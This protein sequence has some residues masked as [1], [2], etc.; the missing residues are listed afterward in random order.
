MRCGMPPPATSEMAETRCRPFAGAADSR[1]RS[2]TAM[3]T[4]TAAAVTMAARPQ[5]AHRR[6][7][8]HGI[9]QRPLE[10]HS[11]PLTKLFAKI[12]LLAEQARTPL[13]H[14]APLLARLVYGQ[15]FFLT[16]RG[17]WGRIDEIV[18]WFDSMH[19]PLAS[20]QAPFVATV[21]LV[22]GISLMLGLGTRVAAFLLS[23]TM[24][25]AL[26]TA[27]SQSFV[28]ALFLRGKDSLPAVTPVP[29]LLTLLLLI[30]FG[31]GK[32]SVDALLARRSNAR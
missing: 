4:Q 30:A 23:G 1:G 11:M 28:D 17:K 5:T 25:V 6:S 29:F 19:I 27:D 22:G 2:G 26:L 20:V 15:A 13:L 10:E 12:T 18:Q 21:E 32:I 14:L 24:V 31:P 16:G 8:D 3:K 7:L 9:H